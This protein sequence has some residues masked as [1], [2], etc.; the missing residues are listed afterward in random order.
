MREL[1]LTMTEPQARFF[2]LP[3]KYPLFC[4]GYGTGKTGTLLNCAVR[5][6]L[7]APGGLI[8]LLIKAYIEGL[9]VNLASG[10]VYPDFDRKL[11]HSPTACS[12][13]SRCTSVWTSTSTRWP[14]LCL[15]SEKR[16]RTRLLS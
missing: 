5:D 12:Q 14:R 6:A 3:D 7:E 9:F 10:S 16:S 13:A 2:Q 8:A 11:N 15:L 4:G 1:R